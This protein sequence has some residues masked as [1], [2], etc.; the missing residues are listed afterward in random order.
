MKSEHA[1][2]KQDFWAFTTN[3]KSETDSHEFLVIIAVCRRNQSFWDM[4]PDVSK[5]CCVFKVKRLKNR[6]LIASET[7]YPVISVSYPTGNASKSLHFVRESFQV[8][9]TA[10]F[11]EW[12]LQ[13]KYSYI[14]ILLIHFTFT[15]FDNL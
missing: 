5:V 3:Y 11:V 9:F 12:S 14:E 4:A 6:E 2:P 7:D 1:L 13:W 10:K 15:Y 8:L